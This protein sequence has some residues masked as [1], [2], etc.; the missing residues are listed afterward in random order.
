[1]KYINALLGLL[2]VFSWIFAY[3]LITRRGL[4]DK[5]YGMPLIP[6]ALNLG[7]EFVFSFCFPLNLYSQVTN[8]LWFF[9]DLGIVYT[10]FKYGYSSFNKFYG[11][12]KKQWYFISVFAFLI[13]F[14]INFLGYK[15]FSQY[16]NHFPSAEIPVLTAWLILLATPACMLAMFFQR[17]NSQGQS[18]IIISI[19]LLGNFFFILQ[20][21]IN[22]FYYKWSNP[23]LVLIITVSV[24]IELYYAKL[25][26]KQLIKEGL[27]PW[28]RF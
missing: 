10:Y 6:L 26:Y 27:N 28:K 15:F 4:K 24:V 20:F 14:L 8:A 22:P 9:C 2:G 7:W 13:G 25:L 18:F 17:R 19:M 1:M 3:V 12:E 5:T 16:L 21:F 11:L 23:F